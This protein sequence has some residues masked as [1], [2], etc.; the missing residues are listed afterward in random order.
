[1]IRPAND[2]PDKSSVEN[3]LIVRPGS[4]KLEHVPP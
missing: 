4:L 2:G 3:P 1:M